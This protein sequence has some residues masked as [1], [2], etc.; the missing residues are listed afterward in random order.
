M[1]D[2][3][4]QQNP[5]MAKIDKILQEFEGLVMGKRKELFGVTLSEVR[6]LCSRWG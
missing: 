6:V 3:Y 5:N 2:K 1:G 4:F